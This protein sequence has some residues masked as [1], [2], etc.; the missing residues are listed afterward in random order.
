MLPYVILG[1]A[2]VAGLLLAGRWF[3]SAN[4]KTLI[5]FFKWGL[6]GLVGAIAIFFLISGRVGWAFATIPALIPWLFRVRSAARMAK[7]FSRMADAARGGRRHDEISEVSTNYVNM[8]LDHASGRMT[9]IVTAGKYS[10]QRI[11]DMNITVLMELCSDCQDD[12]ETVRLLEAYLNREYPDWRRSGE[13]ASYDSN[14]G[15]APS[16]M[17]YSEALR[18]LGLDS[19]ASANDIKEAYR[20]LIGTLHPDHGGSD[21]LTSQINRAK[22]VLLKENS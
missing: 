8:V 13:G 19:T 11:E 10:G 7:T 22:D 9:G 6:I 3:A 20:R 14:S 5:K 2:I 15:L 1:V 21:Y 18:V 4:A 17:E 16:E 12:A